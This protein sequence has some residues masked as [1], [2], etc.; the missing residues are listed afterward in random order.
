VEVEAGEVVPHSFDAAIEFSN[1][2][3]D[4]RCRAAGAWMRRS[5]H[6]AIASCALA[7]QVSTQ[8][9]S[10][11]V[12]SSHGEYTAIEPGRFREG[13][14]QGEWDERPT[15]EVEISRR[16]E[17][18]NHPVSNREYERFRPSHGQVRSKLKDFNEDESPAV[19]VSWEDASAYCDWL[20]KQTGAVHRLPTEAE[21]EFACR[22]KPEI[23]GAA[24]LAPE[25]WCF[26]WY[27]PYTNE[28]QIDPIGYETGD[29][30]VVRGGAYR[31]T[32]DHISA[33]NRLSNLPDDRNRAVG[34]RVVRGEFPKSL[35]MKRAD[36]PRWMAQV[37][38]Q[39]HNWQPPVDM[40]KPY[41]AEPLPYVLIPEALREGP[42]FIEHN[43][44]PAITYCPNGDVLAIWY[45]TRTETG[46]ELA[47]AAAR[48]RNGAEAWD[49]A[50]LFWD[51]ADRN[52]H[53]PALWTDDRGTIYHFNGLGVDE[54]WSE[55]A[56]VMRT[57]MDNGATWSPPRLINDSHGFRNQA[58]AGA[59]G[60][61][62]GHIYL[63][64]D[65]VPGGA[66]GTALHISS[67]RGETWNDFGQ[68]KM[69]PAFEDGKTGSWIA[70]IHAGVAKTDDCQI[71]ALG[72]G[73][74]IEGRMPMSV[75]NDGGR[76]WTY[77]AS[78]FS[79]LGGGQRPV[80]RCLS[81]G[82]LLL[83]SFTRRST[84]RDK[85]DHEYSGKGMFA[86]IS[87]DGGKTWP[88]QKLLTDGKPR[89]LDGNA[90][91]DKFKMDATHAEPKG[92]LAATQTPDGLIHL[93]SSGVHYR[94]NLA[95]LKTP[96]D[97]VK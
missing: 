81:E 52:D 21:W 27:G 72:R 11:D 17:I 79:P 36:K 13:D 53:A 8:A 46:R 88:I 48:F 37:D 9:V 97:P 49:E 23:F 41:F 35:P 39:P 92:Y 30:R 55:L 32:K 62:D 18:A 87:E 28:P 61:S 19:M 89:A 14:V 64:C 3:M 76:T 40:T 91:T 20:T 50:D 45:T 10:K 84:F 94:F 80:L 47:L 65:A 70:G 85:D 15:Q 66:G 38:Q 78:P 25:E 4:R 5:L 44:D 73:N 69:A 7:F 68:G 31:S 82:P 90:W 56:L 95:W 67:D 16:F 63:P 33:T 96:A 86:A 51:V 93:I 59:F 34:F 57:S 54:G 58:I 22:Q 24:E 74:D 43:H 1:V 75:S 2:C 29:A 26:D 12:A 83:I 6:L 60:D 77:S 42:L 71:I